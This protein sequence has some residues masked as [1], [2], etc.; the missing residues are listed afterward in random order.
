[1]DAMT[2][3][4]IAE[5]MKLTITGYMV[6]LQQAGLS[7]VEIEAMFQEAKAGMLERDPANLP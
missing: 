5:L 6:F 3:A 4:A 2:I 1:M 7:D